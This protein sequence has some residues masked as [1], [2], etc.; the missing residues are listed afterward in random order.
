[1][2][3]KAHEISSKGD[4]AWLVADASI[5]AVQNGKTVNVDGRLTAVLKRIEKEMGLCAVTLLRAC[6]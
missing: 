1:V 2:E 4:V 6:R 3:I 5:V